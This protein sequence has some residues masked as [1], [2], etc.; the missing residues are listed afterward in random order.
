M[1]SLPGGMTML[2]LSQS[3]SRDGASE[4]VGYGACDIVVG[5]RIEARVVGL[6]LEQ[7]G[8][9]AGD[10]LNIFLVRSHWLFSR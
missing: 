3:T 9:V 2:A 6:V 8:L 1:M 10:A 5:H 4:F 7:A